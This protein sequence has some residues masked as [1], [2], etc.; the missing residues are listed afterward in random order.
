MSGTAGTTGNFRV[1]DR[2]AFELGRHSL[3]GIVVEDRGHIGA[4]GRRLLRVRLDTA[5]DEPQVI[6]LPEDGL[7]NAPTDRPL[8]DS[9]ISDYL[10]HGGLI[11]I[12][13]SN[14]SGGANQPKAWLCRDSLGNVTHTFLQER[15]MVGGESV[16]FFALHGGDKIFKPKILEVREFLQSFQL[17]SADV[18]RIIAAVG[19][20]P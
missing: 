4:S 2:V 19:T 15:G 18:E 3:T 12:L 20:A 9:D 6:E 8:D 13:R 1:G 10:A 7:H 14:L 17:S 16:P 5:T 11:S